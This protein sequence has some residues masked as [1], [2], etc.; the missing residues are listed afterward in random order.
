M[1]KIAAILVAVLAQSVSAQPPQ[2]PQ[3]IVGDR[4]SGNMKIDSKAGTVIDTATLEF[5]SRDGGPGY[6][7]DFIARHPLW[8]PVPASGVVDIVVTQ[9]A[10]D[11][12]LPAMTLRVDDDAVPLVTRLRSRR[13][14][15]ATVPLA[16]IERIVAGGIVVERTFG[17]ELELGAGQL[18]MLRATA[19]RWLGRVR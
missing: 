2:S 17:T 18:K 8:Q 19:D 7:I 5:V 4:I 9:Q 14:V 16:E 12:E 1:M 10:A 11:D 15:V 6:T 3:R 13:S